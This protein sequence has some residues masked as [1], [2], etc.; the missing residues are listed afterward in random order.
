VV[1][2]KRRNPK[3]GRFLPEY[4]GFG[5]ALNALPVYAVVDGISMRLVLSL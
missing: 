5:G 4:A 1:D 2:I 3:T